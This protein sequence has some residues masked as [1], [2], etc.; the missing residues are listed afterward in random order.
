MAQVPDRE[1][2]RRVGEGR[3]RGH[4]RDGCGTVVDVREQDQRHVAIE[5]RGDIDGRQALDRVGVEPADRQPA[6]VGQAL[7]DVAIRREFVTGGDDRAPGRS[8]IE[9]RGG[10]AVQV[11]ARGI[12]HDRLAR[13]CP[14]QRR[15]DPVADPLGPVEPRVPAA[16][17]IAA[18]A[19]P[20]QARQPLRGGPRQAP[21][22]VAVEVHDRWV[23]DDEPVPERGERVGRVEFLGGG[24]RPGSDR[25]F[26]RPLHA[27]SVGR[28]SPPKSS[29]EQPGRRD[30]GP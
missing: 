22:R 29:G 3:D 5:G 6:G 20:D 25:P 1:R 7:E 11:H 21:E 13:P 18:P 30:V 4:V 8:R 23:V 19:I 12:R 14:E 16:D 27:A 10:Q 2:A 26:L 15:P 9:S 28:R 24:V 17:E